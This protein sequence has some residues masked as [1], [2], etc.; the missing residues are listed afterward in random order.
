MTRN[1]PV[2]TQPINPNRI[3]RAWQKVY[4][5]S[6]A[7]IEWLKHATLSIELGAGFGAATLLPRQPPTSCH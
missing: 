2:R 3:L 1:G 6:Q 4:S 7:L 5:A